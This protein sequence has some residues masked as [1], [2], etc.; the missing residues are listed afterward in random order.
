MEAQIRE[1]ALAFTY[2]SWRSS[3]Y[4]VTDNTLHRKFTFL[5]VIALE[6]QHAGFNALPSLG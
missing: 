5:L 1:F 4:T 3:I 6:R 2:Y